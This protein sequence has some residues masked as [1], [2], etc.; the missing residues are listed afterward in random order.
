M[1]DKRREFFHSR[2]FHIKP[3][4]ALDRSKPRRTA[5]PQYWARGHWKKN[6]YT[7]MAKDMKSK[8]YIA[9]LAALTLAACSPEDY[10]SVNEAG[11]PVAQDAK[12]KVDVDDETNT[13][14]LSLEGAGQYVM[15]Y[16]PVDG[17]EITKKA[18]YSTSN[19]LTRIWASAGDYTVYYRVGNSNAHGKHRRR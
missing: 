10:D 12:A 8:I 14:T 9:S 1:D 18:I 19:P 15:W 11:L 17:K 16:L 2:K 3:K 6:L 13:V 5:T 4:A 7:K